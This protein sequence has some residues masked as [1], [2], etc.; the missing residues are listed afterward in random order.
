MR[1]FTLALGALFLFVATANAGIIS[2]SRVSFR[3]VH[4]GQ[5]IETWSWQAKIRNAGMGDLSC[6]I[7]ASFL[8]RDGFIVDEDIERIYIRGNETQQVRGQT[9]THSPSS[10]SKIEVGAACR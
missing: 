4:Q 9:V 1:I 10:I 6:S 7:T 3:K 2:V 8:D 5:T